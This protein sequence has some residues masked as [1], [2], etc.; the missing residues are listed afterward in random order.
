MEGEQTAGAASAAKIADESIVQALASCSDRVLQEEF[1][2]LTN[3][4]VSDR[5]GRAYLLAQPGGRLA[6]HTLVTLLKSTVYSK[7]LG[8]GA[9]GAQAGGG[10]HRVPTPPSTTCGRAGSRP[11]SANKL[12]WIA[13]TGEDVSLNLPFI[14]PPSSSAP[15]G[16]E[17]DEGRCLV[18]RQ[19]CLIALQKL[20]LRR[21]AQIQILK[22]G[23]LPWL[24]AYLEGLGP[25]KQ[26]LGSQGQGDRQGEG[27]G[28]GGDREEETGRR[29]RRR[30]RK[31]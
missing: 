19:Q 30:K 1:A 4:V 15:A 18:L 23:L 31:R 10:G 21:Q 3:A 7:M 16:G 27:Q 14:P 6:V 2:R 11:G 28:G 17:D 24:L 22:E 12:L 5:M 25:Q 8:E 13:A 26:H 20:S 9:A 29:R